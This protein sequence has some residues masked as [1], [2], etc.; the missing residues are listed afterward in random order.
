MEKAGDPNTLKDKK[1]KL[2]FQER[3]AKNELNAVLTS[4]EG[5]AVL[6][7]ILEQCGVWRSSYSLDDSIYFMEGQRNIGL[8]LLNEIQQL[9]KERFIE[10]VLEN[11][12][13]VKDDRRDGDGND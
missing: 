9:S 12:Q 2:R 3:A 7:R 13:E 5:R 6:W 8:W 1:R 10:M 11:Q 4:R